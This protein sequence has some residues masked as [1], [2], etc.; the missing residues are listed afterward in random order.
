MGMDPE[1]IRAG[2]D[3]RRTW[4]EVNKLTEKVRVIESQTRQQQGTI[5]WLRQRE[6]WRDTA[7][8]GSLQRCYVN[9]VEADFLWCVYCGI[10]GLPVP[11]AVPFPV[12]KPRELRP[13]T[14]DTQLI[15]GWRYAY[16]SFQSRTRTYEA[17]TV[18]GVIISGAVYHETIQPAYFATDNQLFATQPKG[19]TGATWT[20]EGD[21]FDIDWLDTN[22]DA[23]KWMPDL[24]MVETCKT[25][26][27]VAVPGHLVVAGGPGF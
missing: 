19:R 6:R 21:V 10:D 2:E 20:T 3:S 9:S 14:Y 7:A 17:A 12:A 13:S 23:R 22:P 26:A 15:A 4:R 1:I 5:E 27:G 8:G 18:P 16:S 25:V 24:T 11:G